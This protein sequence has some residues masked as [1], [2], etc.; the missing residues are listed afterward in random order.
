M[1]VPRHVLKTLFDS[2]RFPLIQ[3]HVDS[4]NDLLDVGIPTYIRNS[5]PFELQVPGDRF[6][7]VYIGGKDGSKIRYQSPT[8]EDGSALVPHACR[9]DNRTYALS[10]YADIEAEYLFPDKTTQTRSFSDV[11][12]GKIPLMLRSRLCYLTGLPNY[13]I[14]E[15]KFELGGYF[16]IDGAEKVLLTQELLG[17]NMF[18]AGSRKRKAPKGT[19]ARLVQS[20]EPITFEDV[21][22]DADVTYEEVTETYVGIKTFSEDGVRGPYS[23]FL[24]IPSETLNPEASNGNY[25]R[26]NRL[27]MM[28]VRGFSQP[29][30]L[31]SLFR[32]L[33][34][35]SDRDLYDTV[36]AGVP[37]KDRTAYDE[38]F[39]QLVLSHD[40]FLGK[41]D[42]TD[43][44]ILSEFT[45]SKSRFEIVQA[46]H[47]SLFSHVEGS[48]DDT[49][50]L[51]RR[52]AYM[53]GQMLKM[54]LD[55]EIGRRAPSDRDSFQFKRFKTSGVLVF[56]EF[57][58]IY[59]E[60]GKE[61][62]LRLDRTNTFNP[63][64]YREKNLANLIEPETIGRFWR[65]CVFEPCQFL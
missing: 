51:F 30:P 5:N 8:E 10:L 56:D 42:R 50:A 38:I 20:D 4:F 32:A 7:R 59:R 2:A 65:G 54:A 35:T 64:T 57:R 43:L 39:Y 61:M 26:D 11:L 13:E 49:G 15:C 41:L 14:G 9:L 17:D 63:T 48:T 19:K 23:H 29:I 18:Y 3:H 62:L 47:E 6:V 45:R 46:L 58:R 21:K 16:I 28:N 31:L 1:D 33:G 22:E 55:V 25:G 44:S 24:T 40:K 12:I 37:D 53:L 52:K 36:L 60:N 34:V 27:A